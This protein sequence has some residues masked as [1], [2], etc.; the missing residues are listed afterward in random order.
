MFTI[1][2]SATVSGH[3]LA[4]LSRLFHPVLVDGYVI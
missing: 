1:V 4:V 2:P 3:L